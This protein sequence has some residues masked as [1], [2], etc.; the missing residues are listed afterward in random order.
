MFTWNA[1]RKSFRDH[2]S[3]CRKWINS[4]IIWTLKLLPKNNEFSLIWFPFWAVNHFALITKHQQALSKKYSFMMHNKNV[5]FSLFE[6]ILVK[7]WTNEI[8]ERLLCFVFFIFSYYMVPRKN[9]KF[10]EFIWLVFLLL[11]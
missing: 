4:L 1:A 3:F 5:N 9:H 7:E 11:L 10:S 8:Y 6:M 2:K